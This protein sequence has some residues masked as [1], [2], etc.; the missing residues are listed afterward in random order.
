MSQEQSNIMHWH[1]LHVRA[2]EEEEIA[3]VIN[4]NQDLEAFVPKLVR[5]M[6]RNGVCIHEK[7]RLFPNYVFIKSSLNTKE[8]YHYIQNELR[9]LVDYFRVLKYKDIELETL[10]ESEKHY[11]NQFL[12]QDYELKP[13]EGFIVGK[14]VVITQGPLM[15][16]ESTIVFI[17]RHKRVADISLK[18]FGEDKILRVGL[19]ILYKKL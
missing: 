17:D 11:L 19:D 12:D 8:F 18:L 13:S 9:P 1:I 14:N 6:K 16:L 5:I 7:K 2:H 15:G 10:S 3:K 4:Q